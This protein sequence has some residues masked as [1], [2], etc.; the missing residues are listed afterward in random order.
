M[1]SL[2]KKQEKVEEAAA[3]DPQQQ[4]IAAMDRL[5][6]TIERKV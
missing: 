3:P 5:T 4:L 1:M 2:R 6:A